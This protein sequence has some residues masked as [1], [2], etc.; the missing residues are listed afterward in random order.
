MLH[1]EERIIDLKHLFCDCWKALVLTFCLFIK[2]CVNKDSSVVQLLSDPASLISRPGSLSQWCRNLGALG[3]EVMESAPLSEFGKS[4]ANLHHAQ[5]QALLELREE[6][7][8]RFRSL[9]EEQQEDRQLLW[10]VLA[11]GGGSSSSSLSPYRSP[12]FSIPPPSRPVPM[13]HVSQQ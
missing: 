5:H 13:P 4:L 10:S 6:Q 12:S 11:Q 3:G 1:S 7:D 8:R 9:L 2:E